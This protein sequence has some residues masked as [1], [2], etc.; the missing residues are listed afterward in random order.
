VV[1][2][3]GGHNLL[4]VYLFIF[5]LQDGITPLHI[6]AERGAC[7]ICEILVDQHGVDVDVTKDV[8]RPW[9][10]I[11]LWNKHPCYRY[12]ANDVTYRELQY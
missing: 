3:S 12:R 4:T 2:P 8:S 7:D 6:A 5:V 1:D 11:D 10:Q 9:L